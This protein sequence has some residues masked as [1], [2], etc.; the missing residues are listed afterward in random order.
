MA[1]FQL[2]DQ[3]S[4]L[5]AAGRA[6]RDAKRLYVDTEFESSREGTRMCLLQVRGPEGD[7]FLIDTL[8]LGSLDPLREAFTAPGT[9]WVLHAGMQDVHLLVDR[10]RI[11]PPP[12][13]FDTQ[14]AWALLGPEGSVSLAYLSFRLLGLR[15]SKAHQADDW[16]RRPLGQ[17][18]LEYAA[19][20]VAHLGE[21]REIL[22]QQ[23]QALGREQI[24]LEA[25]RETLSPL[26]EP[27]P[28][29]G[30]ES[31]RNAWQLDPPNQAALRYIIDW[32][33]RLSREDKER[34]PETKVLLSIAS[35][36]PESADA[37]GRIKGV[38]RSFAERKGS[39][40]VAELRRAAESAR[41]EDFV[42]IDPAPYATF[43]EIRLDGWFALARA[44][45]CATVKAAPELVMPGRI[46]KSMH[47]AA[48]EAGRAEGALDALTGWRRALIEPAFLDFCKGK[49]APL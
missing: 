4:A 37:L 39:A 30:L 25:S 44:E 13:L 2:V 49:P 46:L 8:K 1:D 32:Y 38:P 20:D 42:P 35:R 40:F 17:S 18:L 9:E 26:R 29:I 24:V 5:E 11:P 36:L 27:P 22:G 15:S 10:L 41:A 7:T 12:L 21:L 16:T 34:A 19:S 47:V 3:V 33:N 14:I 6:L 31:F 23:A 43:G 28:P 45:V 48:V